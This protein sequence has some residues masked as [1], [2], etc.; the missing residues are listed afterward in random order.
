MSSVPRSRCF[1][2]LN[3]ALAEVHARGPELVGL[4]I[5]AT[6]SSISRRRRARRDIV[7]IV[8]GA[9][10]RTSEDA[11]K[12]L[13]TWR[14]L[15]AD[16][17][18]QARLDGAERLEPPERL[19][20]VVVAMEGTPGKVRALQRSIDLSA[21]AGLEIVVVHVDDEQSIPS[22]SDQVHHETE[23]YAQEFFARHLVG[24]PKMRLEL[25]F[26]DVAD[27]VLGAIES[28]QADLVAV[29]WPH[30]SEPRSHSTRD[31][32]QE[33]GTRMMVPIV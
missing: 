11:E 15:L 22:F 25:R 23:A 8:I 31:R 13:G 2:Q 28:A 27:E 33:P 9:T 5:P 21:R 6:R 3:T 19:R 14:W 1:T 18:R 10:S 12:P 29:G 4:Q 16:A 7:A 32:E 17:D 20:T 30:G 24:A 26:G